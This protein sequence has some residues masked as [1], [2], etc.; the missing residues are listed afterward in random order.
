MKWFLWLSATLYVI[1]SM[2]ALIANSKLNDRLQDR[3]SQQQYQ[4]EV[5]VSMYNNRRPFDRVALLG[6][7]TVDYWRGMVDSTTVDTTYLHDN[8]VLDSTTAEKQ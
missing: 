3:L 6:D 5:L 2:F 7:G 1:F 8:F 4:L